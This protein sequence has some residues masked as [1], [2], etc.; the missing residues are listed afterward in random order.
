MSIF[1]GKWGRNEDKWGRNA[2]TDHPRRFWES[3]RAMTGDVLQNRMGQAHWLSQNEIKRLLDG[4]NIGRSFDMPAPVGD[5]PLVSSILNIGGDDMDSKQM[6]ISLKG[7]NRTPQ[8]DTT[9]PERTI[10]VCIVQFGAGGVQSVAEIDWVNGL[11][12]SV[13]ASAVRISCRNESLA[14]GPQ[15][16]VPGLGV[17]CSYNPA[18]SRLI[19][20]R[21][22][23]SRDSLEVTDTIAAGAFCT[24]QVPEF[25]KD[26]IFERA[27]AAGARTIMPSFRITSITRSDFGA[28]P[29]YIDN[30]ATGV[31]MNP[32]L[33]VGNDTKWIRVINTDAMVLDGRLIFSLA[34]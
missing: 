33:P 34:L 17:F 15:Q 30:V 4:G 1:G 8:N 9:F 26:V 11:T 28:V 21:T 3:R 6:S 7:P 2:E 23:W 25:A 13:P 16:S 19:P 18:P 29:G 24:W 10:I 31:R 12:F 27:N 32:P 14:D 22:F 20:Q 5:V